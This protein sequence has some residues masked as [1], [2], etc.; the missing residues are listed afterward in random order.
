[1]DVDLDTIKKEFNQLLKEF[2]PNKSSINQ[3]ISSN[4]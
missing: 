3:K 1:M 4:L 2:D